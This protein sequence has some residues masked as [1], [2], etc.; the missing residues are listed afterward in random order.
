MAISSTSASP[1]T[2]SDQGFGACVIGQIRILDEV[3]W[4]EYRGGVAATLM[5]FGGE[6]VFRGRNADVFAGNNRCT[7]IVVLRF[8]DEQAA[9]AW[10]A[11]DA[12]Q[13]LVPLREQAADVTLTLYAP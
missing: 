3:K 7:D 11:S 4:A 2:L 8:P 5:P 12:Y 10:H 13:A 9:R 6:A 1:T